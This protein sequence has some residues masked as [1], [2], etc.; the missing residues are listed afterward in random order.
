MPISKN[1]YKR[2]TIID[3]MLR[4]GR[5]ASKDEI[6][7]KLAFEGYEISESMFEKDL[8]TLRNKFDLPI[9]YNRY[10]AGYHYTE[11][12]VHFDIPLTSDAVET[13]WLAISKLKELQNTAAVSNVKRS[14]ESIVRRLDFDMDK[15][16]N[17]AEKI[18]YYDPLPEFSG[19]EWISDIY[20]AIVERRIISFDFMK[21]GRTGRY[22][23]EPYK[24]REYQGRW[25]VIGCMDEEQSLF[26]LDR[27]LALEI[28]EK[29]FEFDEDFAEDIH[30]DLE[31]S[32]GP[33]DFSLRKHDIHI[34]YDRSL[35]DD[36]KQNKLHW[37]Q[38]VI[39]EDD[40]GI[41]IK[42]NVKLDRAFVRKWI[43]PYG[44]NTRVTNPPFAVDLVLREII[45]SL[46]N[47]K[48]YLEERFSHGL[49]DSREDDRILK[50]LHAITK[51][52]S[53]G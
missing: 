50:K 43:L 1:A 28:D 2:F 14:L 52:S 53:P 9:K 37:T 13:I 24:L 6:L 44:N 8:S 29:R 25:Y 3:G 33:L 39:H 15:L 7:E 35:A 32:V 4:S 31:H 36:I 27:I 42:V 18:I 5:Y 11:R 26:G 16:E 21:S 22:T 19:G 45:S 48:G 34:F 46:D 30:F 12:D 23:I 40:A 10:R 47:Y 20:D 38:R 17:D 51:E 41:V 49:D